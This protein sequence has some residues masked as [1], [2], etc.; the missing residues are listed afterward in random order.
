[1]QRKV[2]FLKIYRQLY[3][4]SIVY[5]KFRIFVISLM[6]I[7]SVAFYYRRLGVVSSCENTPEP[8]NRFRLRLRC[9]RACVRAC[10]AARAG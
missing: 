10:E 7:I 9:V 3:F 8:G 5:N 2:F 4:N 1:M 6:F